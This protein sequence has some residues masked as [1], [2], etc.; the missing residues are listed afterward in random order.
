MKIATLFVSLLFLSLGT[1]K[2]DA[3]VHPWSK[4]DVGSWVKMRVTGAYGSSNITQ[5]LKSL[6]QKEYTIEQLMMVGEDEHSSDVTLHFG[7]GGYAHAMPEATKTGHEPLVID[8]T[9]Y[10]CDIWSGTWKS[11]PNVVKETSWVAQGTDLPLK[12][13][14]ESHATR[15]ELVAETLKDTVEVGEKSLMCV[16]YR[17]TKESKQSGNE[18]VVSWRS[19]EVPG[20]LVKLVT[21]RLVG[22]E[23][24]E[25]ENVAIEFKAIP[26]N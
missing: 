5:R 7:L 3:P 19:A 23:T 13:I 17:G 11:G 16:R 12:I 21:T 14:S 20:G 2:R 9:I 25:S 4:W 1:S 24:S 10:E 15:L 18:T 8:S 26:K 22:E 6:G